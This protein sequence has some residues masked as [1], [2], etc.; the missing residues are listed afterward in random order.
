MDSN[1]DIVLG[2]INNLKKRKL[3]HV[4]AMLLEALNPLNIVMAQLLYIGQPLVRG[5]LPQG[6]LFTLAGILEDPE[7]TSKFVELLREE[8]Q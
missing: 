8:T 6:N 2:W 1:Q 4:A 5:V 7:K 3:D